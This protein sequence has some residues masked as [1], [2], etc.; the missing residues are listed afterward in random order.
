MGL[1]METEEPIDR[2]PITEEDL[3]EFLDPR[4]DVPIVNIV[5]EVKPIEH[6]VN[7]KVIAAGVFAIA[8]A[9]IGYR[10]WLTSPTPASE[11]AMRSP[12]TLVPP[13]T[14]ISPEATPSLFPMPT[15]TNTPSSTET[16]TPTQT[17]TSTPLTRADIRSTQAVEQ[18]IE[19]TNDR[20]A[21]EF[22]RHNVV[23]AKPG[24]E[25]FSNIPIGGETYTSIGDFLA[26]TWLLLTLMGGGAIVTARAF[27]RNSR[28]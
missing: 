17:P 18:L 11:N 28:D 21:R 7:G 10:L 4:P 22:R 12:A 26:H 25:D 16:A 13:A 15:S 2:L 8:V 9:S 27:L 19:K 23:I 20:Q 6:K 24:E 3:E 1:F 14:A 5:N